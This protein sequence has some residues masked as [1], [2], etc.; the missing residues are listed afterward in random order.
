M[1]RLR[2]DFYAESL[3]MCTSMTVILPEPTADVG[4]QAHTVASEPPTLYLLHGLS[5]DDTAWT[6][7]TSVERYAAQYGIAV[8]MPQVHRS[9]YTDQ[10][11][12]HRY[13][14]FL[15]QELPAVVQRFFRLSSRRDDTFVAG[16]S[17]GG[18]GAIKWALREPERFAAAASLSGALDVARLS[19]ANVPDDPAIFERAFGGAP[20][21]GTDN[22]LVHLVNRAAGRDLPRLYLCCGTEDHVYPANIRFH[23]ACREASVA[24]ST[25][26]GPGDHD[27]SYWDRT[28]QDVLAWFASGS[29]AREA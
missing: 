15:S 8:I 11:H 25:D 24:I 19:P 1:A 22:D 14:T 4:V 17:M 2:C 18:Y 5:D 20:V 7:Y 26:F 3:G 21:A 28:I 12:G 6:R 13:W 29:A 23:E 27:W 9:F 16:L 10:V